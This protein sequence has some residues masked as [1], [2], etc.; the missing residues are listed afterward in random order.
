M[1]STPIR[2][3]ATP[4]RGSAPRW[5]GS[6]RPA[7]I[8]AWRRAERLLPRDYDLLF[9]LGVVLADG[10]TPREALPYL[11]RFVREAPRDRY[12][13]RHRARRG[14]CFSRVRPMSVRTVAGRCS[15]RLWPSSPLAVHS[16]SER[17]RRRLLAAALPRANVLLV[18]IDTLRADRVGAYGGAAGATPTL[19]RLAAEGCASTPPTR[20]SR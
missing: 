10:P 19:D 14:A 9:N 18:T 16:T 3:A 8:D 4:G 13:G 17:R 2:R 5:S 11:E 15:D 1:R 6:D 20:T 12:A 7:A